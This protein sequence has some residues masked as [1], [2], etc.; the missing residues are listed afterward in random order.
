LFSPKNDI[1]VYLL[2]GIA[3]WSASDSDYSD[4]FLYSVVCLFV[5][6][7]IHPPFLN[8]SAEFDSIWSLMTRCVENVSDPM[9]NGDFGLNPS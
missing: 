7:H 4:A 6:C 5:V 2:G 3:S 9:K 8:R 1:A